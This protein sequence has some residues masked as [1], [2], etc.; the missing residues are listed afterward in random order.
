MG[1]AIM[2]CPHCNKQTEHKTK[3]KKVPVTPHRGNT[4]HYHD[5]EYTCKSCNNVNYIRGKRGQKS[6]MIKM[7][8]E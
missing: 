2:F 7:W 1:F 6:L 4:R 5:T 8:E 3:G